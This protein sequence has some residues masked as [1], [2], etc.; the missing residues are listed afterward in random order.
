[1]LPVQQKIIGSLGYLV[2]LALIVGLGY[3][4]F[5]GKAEY[6]ALLKFGSIQLILI[7]PLTLLSLFVIGF[8]NH[9]MASHLGAKLTVAQWSAVSFSSTLAN[10]LTPMR[11]GAA[12]RATFYKVCCKL[13]L[14]YFASSL[15]AASIIAL[16][17]NSLVGICVT[18]G[19]RFFGD[20]ISWWM[21]AIFLVVSFLSYLSIFFSPRAK[22]ASSG[23]SVIQILIKIH[24]GWELIVSEKLLLHKSCVL[25][26]ANTLTYSLRLYL[27]FSAIGYD[28]SL[29]GSLL[30]GVM[31]SISTV[32]SITPGGLGLRE[33]MVVGASWMIG[34]PAEI[35]LLAAVVDRGISFMVVLLAGSWGSLYTLREIK[36]CSQ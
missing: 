26:L 22:Q 21:L 20:K 31:V 16:L 2:F 35:S 11:A 6:S 7:A 23:N 19:I 10:Y 14:S 12:M 36:R 17:V 32:A 30:L 18:I 4:Y 9:L 1:M 28:V 3:W 25:A 24:Q 15:V 27:A 8:S 33:T 5:S 29:A 13:P 34:V